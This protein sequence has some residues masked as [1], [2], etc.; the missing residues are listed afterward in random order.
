MPARAA[1]ARPGPRLIPRRISAPPARP[2]G[3]KLPIQC[4]HERATGRLNARRAFKYRHRAFIR[5]FKR[6]A[7]FSK[8]TEAPVGALRCH[9]QCLGN[10]RAAVSELP[11]SKQSIHLPIPEGRMRRLIAFGEP[12]MV[13]VGNEASSALAD[14]D[15]VDAAEC[16]ANRKDDRPGWSLLGVEFDGQISGACPRRAGGSTGPLR[17]QALTA[18]RTRLSESTTVE[19][20]SIRR[21]GHGT[22]SSARFKQSC[23]CAKLNL[24]SL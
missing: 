19:P 23:R 24:G 18:S 21:S 6:S 15:L 4:D 7:H 1:R 3:S 5:A 22:T 10:R 13:D 16:L 2:P 8:C 20:T 14:Q 17:A 11:R 12:L 9:L